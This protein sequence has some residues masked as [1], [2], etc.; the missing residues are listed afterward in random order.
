[1]NDVSAASAALVRVAVGLC[2]AFSVSAPLAA[3]SEV[4]WSLF[5]GFYL[6][7]KAGIEIVD[8]DGNGQQVA[9]VT[10]TTHASNVLSEQGFLAVLSRGSDGYRVR[11]VRRLQAGE[12]FRGRIRASSA[13]PGQ[14]AAIHAVLTRDEEAALVRFEGPA[15]RRSAIEIPVTPHF[16]LAGVADLAADGSLKAF[17]HAGGQWPGDRSGRL[18]IIDLG[19]EAVEWTAGFDASNIVAAQLDDDAALELVVS[20]SP[21]VQQTPGYVI[22]GATRQIEWTHPPGFNGA[23]LL[24]GTYI[25]GSGIP[26]FA[27][28]PGWGNAQIFRVSPGYGVHS[29]FPTGSVDFAIAHDLDGDGIDE[30]VAA[31]SRKIRIFDGGGA[32]LRIISQLGYGISDVAAGRLDGSSGP[33]LVVGHGTGSSGPDVLSVIDPASGDE[34]FATAS[35]SGPHSALLVADLDGDG[36]EEVVRVPK[37]GTSGSLPLVVADAGTGA[38]L[39]RTLAM[40]SPATFSIGPSLLAANLDGDP[41]LEIVVG[42]IST[43]RA[44]IT[45]FDGVTLEQ[46]WTLDPPADMYDTVEALALVHAD[47]DGIPDIAASVGRR[48][49]L[50]NGATGTVIWQGVQLPGTGPRTLL[51]EDLDGDGVPELVVSAGSNVYVID[52]QSRLVTRVLDNAAPVIGQAVERRDGGCEHVLYGTM[53]L[54]RRSCAGTPLDSRDYPQATLVRP[55]SDS[56]G[57]LLI[58]SGESLLLDETGRALRTIADGLGTDLG[59]SNRG[60]VQVDDHR[61]D[62]FI[63]STHAVHRI[64]FDAAQLFVDSFETRD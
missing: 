52:L 6:P 59:W 24:P 56:H 20:T 19:S 32:Q 1:M 43:Y 63:G 46:Q 39:R 37:V 41:H 60:V 21:Y 53:S 38:E 55:L 51:A 57:P 14:P 33:V 5:P 22:D 58:A 11:H 8:L 16:W 23:S 31:D 44:R 26:G 29:A 3:S 25:T 7:G 17:G 49:T 42:S 18:Q 10:G 9:V 28:V 40:S 48:P 47:G 54:N 61:V 13:R 15:L 30:I 4:R 2:V 27:V 50:I 35:E 45:A 34:R 62:V 12:T 64:R 36:S